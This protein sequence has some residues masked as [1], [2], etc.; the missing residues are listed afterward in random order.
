MKSVYQHRGNKNVGMN[1]VVVLEENL[2]YFVRFLRPLYN[3]K[4]GQFMSLP[5]RGGERIVPKCKTDMQGVQC[6]CFCSLFCGVV[7]AIVVIL[8]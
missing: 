8:S 5:G 6:L 7:V 1:G 3:L 4:F 2:K